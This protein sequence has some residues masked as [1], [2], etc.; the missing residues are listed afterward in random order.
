MHGIGIGGGMHRDGCDA[1]FLAGAQH[2]KRDLAAIGYE[3]LVEHGA[4]GE[5]VA[6]GGWRM[7]TRHSIRHWPFAIGV[8]SMITSGSP[9]STGWPSSTRIC[10]TVPARG[11]GIWF[12][13]FIA[14]M[15][16]SVWPA[17]TL[18]PTSMNGLAP[19]SGDQ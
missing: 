4:S 5:R 7:V 12:I 13:V 14:S 18:V 2:A 15:I 8:Y 10:V 3:D 17:E 16:R 1:E 9:N 19:G 6:N 11:D